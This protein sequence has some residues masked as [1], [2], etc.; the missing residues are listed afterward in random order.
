MGGPYLLVSLG[1]KVIHRDHP[2]VVWKDGELFR[3]GA[4]FEDPIISAADRDPGVYIVQLR[5]TRLFKIGHTSNLRSRFL[6][7]RRT[8]PKEIMLVRFSPTP[9]AT[10]IEREAHWHVREN[11]HSCEW[12]TLKRKDLAR[13]MAFLSIAREFDHDAIYQR[14]ELRALRMKME[15]IKDEEALKN[16]SP[17]LQRRQRGYTL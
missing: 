10:E 3:R 1:Y 15:Q 12:F 2:Y 13:I 16:N 11:R 4:D 7:L 5:S 17:K 8:I 9:F 6:L 14:N